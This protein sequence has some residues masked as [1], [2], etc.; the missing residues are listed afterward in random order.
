MSTST[1]MWELENTRLRLLGSAA[2]TRLLTCL[3]AVLF[4]GLQVPAAQH[5]FLKL[6]NQFS[7]KAGEISTNPGIVSSTDTYRS[8][9]PA[10]GSSRASRRVAAQHTPSSVVEMEKSVGLHGSSTRAHQRVGTSSSYQWGLM[11]SMVRIKHSFQRGPC[12]GFN[13]DLGTLEKGR[14]ASRRLA[15][16][17]MKFNS[18]VVAVSFT[19]TTR[20]L[21]DRPQS[22]RWSESPW[23]KNIS[24]APS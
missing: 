7:L 11:A 16:L 3:F 8:R 1:K 17:I 13:G 9:S 18:L 5:P 12:N 22:G 23:P 21:P 6:V 20:L 19:P 10:F 2:H 14:S 4:R 15:P 24:A